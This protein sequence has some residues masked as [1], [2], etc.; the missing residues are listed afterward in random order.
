MN[1][2]LGKIFVI[3]GVIFVVLGSVLLLLP[4]GTNP[5]AWFGNLPGDFAYK[6]ENSTIFAPIAS[7]LLVSV[8]LSVGL[9]IF[10]RIFR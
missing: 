8:A 6:G 3:F 10:Q 5:F 1:M 4:K 2:E 9:W 7:M